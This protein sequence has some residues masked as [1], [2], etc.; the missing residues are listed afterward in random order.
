[1]SKRRPAGQ[2]SDADRALFKDA[3]GD[4]RRLPA[5]TPTPARPRPAPRP[6]QSQAD[7]ARVI[8]E[9]LSMEFDPAHL[10]IGE[11]LIYL[12]DGHSPRLLKRL[13]R[14]HYSVSDEIDL[15]QMNAATAATS[16]K[17]FLDETRRE[18]RLCVKVIHGKGLRSRADGPVLKRLTDRMLRQRGDVVAF[19]SARPQ[20]GGSGATLVLLAAP[21]RGSAA[22]S[23]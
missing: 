2:P 17:R 20:Q 1:M 16:L 13:R 4:V 19:A 9:L 18:G 8:D 3:I 7:E 22:G 15:H 6:L 5:S 21:R 10:E 14:G 11:E 23:T 12:K